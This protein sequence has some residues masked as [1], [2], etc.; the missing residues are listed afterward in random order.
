VA[1]KIARISLQTH[2]D[3]ETIID[4]LALEAFIA[5]EQPHA[6]LAEIEQ[7]KPDVSLLPAGPFELWTARQPHTRQ[8]AA[9]G[10]G[11]TLVAKWWRGGSANVRVTAVTPELAESVLEQATKGAERPPEAGSVPIG[12]WHYSST[13]GPIRNER[14]ISA[15]TW[16][17]I[18]GN[19]A[20]GV[21]AAIDRLCAITPDDVYGRLVLLHGMPGTG[22]TTALRALAHEWRAW[23]QV[24]CVLDPDQLFDKTDYLME[25]AVGEDEDQAGGRWRLIL[26]EDCDE[27]IRGEAKHSTGQ[28]LSRLL[29][30]TDGLLGQGRDVLVGITTNEDLGRLH[31]AVTRPGRCI[32]HIEVGP[33]PYDQAVAWLGTAEHVPAEGATLAELYALR[34]GHMPESQSGA[35][36]FYL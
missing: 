17:S 12:F 35:G 25:A 4:I 18:R 7:V 16:A 1:D 34:A 19:Y 6:R 10:D 14:S 27:L 30:L 23:C 28:A 9:R 21:A 33:L 22:K 13:S 31:P 32:A 20:P 24:D 29:N 3:P 8:H 2:D 5:G 26:L 15:P 11:W 36:G